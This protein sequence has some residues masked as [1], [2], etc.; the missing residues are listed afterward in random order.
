MFTMS[1]KIREET[2]GDKHPDAAIGYGDLGLLKHMQGEYDDAIA[3]HEKALTIQR[4]IL[5]DLHPYTASVFQNLGA[6][7]YEKGM[8]DEALRH[9]NETTLGI[10]DP[11]SAT[12]RQWV[13][14]VKDAI[15]R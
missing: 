4:V 2:Y 15:A 3:F 5:G 7:C 6:A 12:A 9:Q 1:L 8:H 11:K 10:D 14:I 13:E